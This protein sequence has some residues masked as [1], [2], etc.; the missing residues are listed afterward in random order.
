M[1]WGVGAAIQPTAVD[2]TVLHSLSLLQGILCMN[3]PQCMYLP[4]DDGHLSCFQ[5]GATANDAALNTLSPVTRR[6]CTAS[7]SG[8]VTRNRT[9]ES[10]GKLILDFRRHA[11]DFPKWWHRLPPTSHVFSY[12]LPS[13]SSPALGTNRLLSVH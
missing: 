10:Q 1:N 6:T 13:T 8:F 12:L 11:N 3:T 7:V 4:A 9:N 2:V 5:L